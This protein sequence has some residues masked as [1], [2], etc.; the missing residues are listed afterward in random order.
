MNIHTSAC[1]SH[2]LIRFD[3]DAR[4]QRGAKSAGARHGPQEDEGEVAADVPLRD[5]RG[6]AREA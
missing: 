5:L 3:H 4:Q 1:L 6:V 2:G